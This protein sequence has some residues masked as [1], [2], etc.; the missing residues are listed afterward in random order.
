MR[1]Y[2]VDLRERA[3]GAVAGGMPQS[4]AA[5]TFGVGRATV[6][7]WV[8][9]QRAGN[10]GPAPVGGSAPRIGPARAGAL[11][12]QVA[13]HPDATLAEHAERWGR[14]QGVRVSLWAL[15]RALDRLGITRKKRRST[16]ASRTR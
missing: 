5:R 1:A 10:L 12:A 13:A 3:V 16:P 11:R 4:V 7:R 6:Q 14:E 15:D 8:R 2:S 9:R